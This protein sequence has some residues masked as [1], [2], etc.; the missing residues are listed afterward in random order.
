[1]QQKSRPFFALSPERWFLIIALVFG[2]L[3]AFITPPFRVPDEYGHMARAY[4]ISEG[5]FLATKQDDKSGS[6]VPLSISIIG[7]KT[8]DFSLSDIPNLATIPLAP[9]IVTFAEHPNMALYSPVVY[10][11]QAVGFAV[12][13][14]LNVPAI[15]SLYVAR[16]FNVI[17]YS[18]LVYVAIRL[19]PIGKW[20]GAIV[21]LLPM[22]IMLAGSLSADPVTIGLIAVL[23]AAV[24]WLRSLSRAVQPIEYAWLL[25]LTAAIA[26]GKLPYPLLLLLFLFV[27][28]RV[29]GGTRARWWLHMGGLAVA[30]LIAGGGW[31]LLAK[32][33]LVAYGPAGVNLADQL[34]LVLTHPLGFA[35]AAF[36]T[37]F[38]PTSDGF[39]SQIVLAIG[40][41]ETQL[42]LW[43]TYLYGIFLAFAV[44]PLRV[45]GNMPLSRLQ[46]ILT[47]ALVAAVVGS[48]VLLLYLSWTPVGKPI[49]E[50]MQ[51]RYL[52][53]FLFLLI[54]LLAMRSSKANANAGTL[55]T[56][57]YQY[58][59]VL[60]LTAGLAMS[61][62]FFY[63]A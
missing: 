46:K 41:L 9:N 32:A 30:G 16:L 28:V 25:I 52:T 1:M 51:A 58:V 35:K 12:A 22:H 48:M 61:A 18:L 3:F 27:P 42:P 63:H 54:P 56:T 44:F 62:Y 43:L 34:H 49:V 47:A 55:S 29:F 6:E 53:P 37:F 40:Y 50:G 10:A 60:F 45:E 7:M 26:L 8:A 23:V 15:I 36:M 14:A 17:A 11:P 4:G 57:W 38:T 2:A 21:G 24:L 39:M 59:P 31:L 5:H 13:R 20:V 33:T 19:L